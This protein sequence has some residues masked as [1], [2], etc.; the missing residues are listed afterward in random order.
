MTYF[1][2]FPK[3]LYKFGNEAKAVTFTDFSIFTEVVDD[4]KDNISVYQNYTILNNDRPDQV[5]FKLYGSAEYYWTFYLMNDKIREQGWPLNDVDLLAKVQKDFPGTT[6]RTTTDIA[7]STKFVTGKSIR[8]ITSGTVA[9]IDHR[10]LDLGLITVKGSKTFTQGET[11]VSTDDNTT[12]LIISS[13]SSEYLSAH[14]WEDA[15]GNYIDITPS[16]SDPSIYTKVTNHDNYI[17]Q[18]NLLKTIRVIK[19]DTI[20]DIVSAFKTVLRS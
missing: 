8:G 19:R 5:S 2:D 1:F 15:S 11:A 14:H 13:S 6:I 12:S 10:N 17:R 18:N 3:T 4:V 7:T 9:E 16:D 20:G